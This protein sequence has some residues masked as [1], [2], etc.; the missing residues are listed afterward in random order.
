MFITYLAASDLKNEI[1]KYQ[2]SHGMPV[3]AFS[4]L[5][6]NVNVIMYTITKGHAD[7]LMAAGN[8]STFKLQHYTVQQQ[9]IIMVSNFIKEYA[10]T[11]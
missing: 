11:L 7:H 9:L 10:E 8:R 2:C 4:T 3:Y 1:L 5:I 6:L